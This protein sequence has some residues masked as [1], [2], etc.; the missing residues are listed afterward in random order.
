MS[1]IFVMHNQSI[2]T[3][4]NGMRV[5][6]LRH[7][8]SHTKKA[9]EQRLCGKSYTGDTREMERESRLLCTPH[10]D[11]TTATQHSMSNGPAGTGGMS[12]LGK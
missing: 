5:Q 7:T 11:G 12:S 9:I 4:Y 10:Q 1:R 6:V 3:Q 8:H 2:R